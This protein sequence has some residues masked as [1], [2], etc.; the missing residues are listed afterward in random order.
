MDWLKLIIPLIFVAVWI[1][2]QLAKNKE[3]AAGRA[4]P[5]PLPLDDEEAPRARRSASEVDRFLEEVRRRR[6]RAEGRTDSPA[7]AD[8]PRSKPIAQRPPPRPAPEPARSLPPLAQVPP[9]LPIPSLATPTLPLP[10]PPPLPAPR[11]A[12]P[13]TSSSRLPQAEIA[14]AEVVSADRLAPLVAGTVARPA[15]SPAVMQALNLL[16][17]RQSLVAAIVLR[18]ILGPPV[19]KRKGRVPARRV[20]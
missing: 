15:R 4:K 17:S 20:S 19:S 18:E 9:P 2:S 11:K 12:T 16:G 8:R 6:A 7:V 10:A 14:I 3:Q 13:V 1:I 5:P